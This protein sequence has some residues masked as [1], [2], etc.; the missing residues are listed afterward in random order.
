MSASARKPDIVLILTDDHAAHAV[1]AYGSVVN[2]TPRIDEIA[3]AGWRLDHCYATNALCTPSRAS[4]LTGTYSHVN[5]V[6]TLSTPIDASLPTFVTQLRDAGY[7]TGI[8]GKWHMGHGDGHDPQGFDYWDVLIEQGEYFDPTFLSAQGRR[9]VPGYATDVITDLALGWADSLDDDAPLCLLICHKAPHRSWEPDER[10]KD[11][12]SGPIPVPATFTDDYATR[13]SSAR[14]SAMRV[15]DH[16]TLD[17]LKTEPPAGLGYD[18]LALWKYQRYMEDYL[19]CVASVDDNVGRV[20]DWLRERGRLD[21]TLLMYSSDQGFFLGDHGWFDKRY[22]YEESIRMPFVLS[23]PRRLPAGGVHAGIVTNVDL[24]RTVLEA[25]GVPAHPGMQGRSFFADLAGD[26]EPGD[27]PE[28]FYYRYWEHDDGNHL[29]AAHYGYR[30]SRYKLIYFYN[31]GLGLPGTGPGRYPGE[32]ELYDLERDPDELH[33]VAEDP[34]Y[35]EAR[36][37]LEVALWEAQAAVG[38]EPHPR[39]PVPAGIVG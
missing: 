27:A 1:G 8:V 25:A 33:N 6:T 4:I 13:T 31:D 20:T 24:A 3:D 12:Y 17:D 7:R 29:A 19:R 35:A 18:E 26:G 11:L 15:A 37:R 28:G 36:A 32:W 2:T 21:D 39:Q 16:L 23:Y 34:R 5:G 10:H 22:M 38:D 9:T 14:R 30:D